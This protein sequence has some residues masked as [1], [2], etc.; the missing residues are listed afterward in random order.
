MVVLFLVRRISKKWTSKSWRYY[1]WLF[2][3]ARLLLPFS[4]ETSIVGTVFEQT[5]TYV[6]QVKV[7]TQEGASPLFTI[8]D[9]V[10]A[11]V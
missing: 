8:S 1:I 9:P 11:E 3:I 6:E 10:Q 4:P 5:Y 2:I 7:Q